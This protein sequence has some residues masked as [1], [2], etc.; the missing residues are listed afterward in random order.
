MNIN[1]HLF[2]A[3]CGMIK[4]GYDLMDL[5]DEIVQKVYEWILTADFEKNVCEYFLFA[6]TNT[7]SVN[8]YYP[9][10]SDLSA[11]CFFHGGSMD[12]YI[13]FLQM[14]ESQEANNPEF[15]KWISKLPSVLEQIENSRTFDGIYQ[16]YCNGVEKRFSDIQKQIEEIETVLKS[17]PF[18]TDISVVFAPNLL[19]AKFLA[20]YALVEDTLYIISG[21]FWSC[22]IIHEY[23]HIALKPI[24]SMLFDIIHNDGIDK[25]VDVKCMHEL[26][27]LH[28]NTVEAKAHALDECFVR[29]ICGVIDKSLDL[30]WY[31]QENVKNGFWA[32]PRA[33]DKLAKLSWQ[34]MSLEEIVIQVANSIE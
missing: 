7:I 3:Y 9:R 14:C 22:A 33:I 1:K 16:F 19:Q 31:C 27:Y 10:G 21:N 13:E 12:K 2:A 24:R 26:G 28:G 23:L 5:S 34:D 17:K 6:K 29:A 32:V 8:P 18:R 30:S 25:Y 11:A 15:I 20:D 4:S